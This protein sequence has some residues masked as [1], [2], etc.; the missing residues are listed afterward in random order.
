MAGSDTS[1]PMRVASAPVELGAV[2]VPIAEFCAT[3]HPQNKSIMSNVRIVFV[4]AAFAIRI[5]SFSSATHLGMT[6]ETGG[7]ASKEE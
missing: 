2:S 5:Y 4:S 3:M 6:E 1:G 7:G